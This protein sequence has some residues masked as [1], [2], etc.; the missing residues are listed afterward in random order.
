M[1][2]IAAVVQLKPQGSVAGNLQHA[3][4]LLRKA[5]EA[6][7]Q[8]AVLPEN[9]AYYGQSDFLTAGRAESDDM[10]LARQFVAQQAKKYGLWLVGGTIP[11]AE[12]KPR[13]FVR[14][15]VYNPKAEVVGYYDKIH[16]FDA[17]L[18]SQEGNSAYRESDDF[19]AGE[20]VKTVRTE[21][22]VLGLTVCYDLRFAELF[23]RLSNSGAE[24]VTV[25][26]AFTAVTGEAH[27][28]VLL[29]ARAIENQLFVLGANMVDRCHETRGLWGGSA[30]I[31]PWGNV[32]ASLDEQP[33]IA[34]A[35][36]DLDLIG[37]CRSKIPM[38]QH[39]RLI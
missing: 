6:G 33:G 17:D 2:I 34:V 35:E 24:I 36:I 9:F 28:Q 25:P 4:S 32:L 16:L 29:R 15:Y 30:I 14:C 5:A 3:E 7:A 19:S 20:Q 12:S 10:G 31:D 23:Q 37:Q 1:K 11:V 38:A 39:R 22:G 18:A 26:S 21:L 8:L 27:W 13:S